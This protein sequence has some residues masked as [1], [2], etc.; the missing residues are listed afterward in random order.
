MPSTSTIRSKPKAELPF[1]NIVREDVHE[2]AS[3]PIKRDSAAAFGKPRLGGYQRAE[4]GNLQVR[5]RRSEARRRQAQNVYRQVHGE[6]ERQT[7]TGDRSG[8]RRWRH[9]APARLLSVRDINSPWR[10]R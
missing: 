4:D 7:R 1:V 9:V 5:R 10:A 2:I 8:Q 6:Q 3:R